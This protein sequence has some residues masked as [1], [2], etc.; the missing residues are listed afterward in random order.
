MSMLTYNDGTLLLLLAALTALSRRKEDR[1][2]FLFLLLSFGTAFFLIYAGGINMQYYSEILCVFVPVSIAVLMRTVRFENRGKRC[3]A[4]LLAASLLGTANLPYAAV[5]REELPQAKFDK[6]ISETPE[7]TLFNYGALD[8]GQY[9]V[10]DIFPN[11]RYFCM[12][13][14][15]SEEMFRE[16]ERYMW[17]GATDYIVSRDLRVE[18]PAYEL[19]AE[20]AFGGFSYYLY[21]N[22]QP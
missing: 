19:V 16:M 3:A 21:K 14:L 8:F 12:L 1:A 20:E 13:N 2:L 17:E 4:V 18:T 5:K 7:A 22:I 9:T 15:P 10:S 6:I 11:C